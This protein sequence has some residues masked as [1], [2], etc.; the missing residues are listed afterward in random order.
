MI[1]TSR[2]ASS[3]PV[4]CPIGLSEPWRLPDYVPLQVPG[5]CLGLRYPLLPI[6]NRLPAALRIAD[7]CGHGHDPTSR[8]VHRGRQAV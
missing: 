4:A 3:V 6:V 7:D 1:F 8:H 2:S 5:Q